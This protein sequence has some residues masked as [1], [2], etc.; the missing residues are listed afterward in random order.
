M[1][2]YS[3][4]LIVVISATLLSCSPPKKYSAKPAENNRF[5]TVF[6]KDSI[7][8]YETEFEVRQKNYLNLLIGSWSIDTMKRQAKIDAE[9]LI[10]ASIVFE[11]NNRFSGKAGCNNMS[12]K[13]VLKGTSIKFSDI[14]T[15]RMYCDR[16]EQETVLLKLLQENVSAYTVTE[17]TLLLRDGSSN[18]IFQASRTQ[19]K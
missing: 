17:S 18:I 13:F 3:I 16:M 19:S 5:D 6:Q 1:R 8:F 4:Q 14:I 10:N 15:T 7:E 2:N 12:G 11:A 9:P